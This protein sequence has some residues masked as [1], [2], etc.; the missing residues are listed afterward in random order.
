MPANMTA[1]AAVAENGVIGRDGDLPWDPVEGD[2]LHFKEETIG[3]PVIM[4]RVTY[5]S[6]VDRLG[7]PLPERQNI[8]VSR[9][10]HY[11]EENVRTVRSPGSAIS[12]ALRIDDAAYVIGGESIYRAL[13]PFCTRMLITEVPGEYEGDARFPDWD[14][15]GW[16]EAGREELSESVALVEYRNVER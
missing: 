1:I 11:H 4:G 2:L 3:H 9:S 6:I 7:G 5:D 8:V 13:L 12:L 16:K 15:R 10:N 14:D